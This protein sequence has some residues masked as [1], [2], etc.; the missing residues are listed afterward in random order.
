MSESNLC[1][2]EFKGLT[3]AI[4]AQMRPNGFIKFHFSSSLRDL[5]FNSTTQNIKLN[6]L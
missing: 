6:A 2:A 5:L 1:N 4:T 3:V